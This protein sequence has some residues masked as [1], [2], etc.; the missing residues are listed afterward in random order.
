MAQSNVNK[1][2]EIED[3]ILKTSYYETKPMA[4]EDAKIKLEETKNLFYTF[5]NIETNKVN[6]LFKLKDGKNYGLIEPE[7]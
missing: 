6:V 5:V 2:T 1:E 4:P 7:M 3:E